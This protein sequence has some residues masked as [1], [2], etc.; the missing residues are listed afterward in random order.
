MWSNIFLLSLLT[1]FVALVLAKQDYYA[2][3]EVKR[4]A[5]A[6]EI[7]KAYRRLSLKYAE[8]SYEIIN[9]H[10]KSNITILLSF[11]TQISP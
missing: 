1:L 9:T 11:I 5:T 6:A 8:S 3:L 7:K 4:T 2:I 10:S